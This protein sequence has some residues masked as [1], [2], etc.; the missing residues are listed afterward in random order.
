MKP[1]AYATRHGSTDDNERKVFR[2]WTALPLNKQ[3]EQEAKEAA[4]RLKRFGI[5]AIFSSPLIR[6]YQ[7]AEIFAKM[8]KLPIIQD[9]RLMGWK[10]GVFEG[11]LEDEV[12]DALRLFVENSSVPPPLGIS[13]DDFESQCGDFLEEILPLAEKEGPFAFFTHNSVLTAFTNLVEG[14]RHKNPR[15][16]ESEKPGGTMEILVNGR[17]YVIKSLGEVEKEAEI[18]G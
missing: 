11:L 10:T 12:D 2:S 6:A 14:K 17:N 5:T 18:A 16:I 15:G 13:L 7:T 8:M 9:R 4:E 3:G 1:I